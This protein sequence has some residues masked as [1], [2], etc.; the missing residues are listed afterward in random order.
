M[1]IATSMAMALA[2]A[3]ATVNVVIVMMM[4]MMM[5]MLVMTTVTLCDYEFACDDVVCMWMTKS[6]CMMKFDVFDWLFDDDVDNNGDV[7]RCC[8]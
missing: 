5:M 1:V 2:M 8:L 6:E 4:M 3:T 7:L